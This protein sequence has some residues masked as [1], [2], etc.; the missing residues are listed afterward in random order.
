MLPGGLMPM[1]VTA[2]VPPIW[3]A[4]MNPRVEAW[5]REHWRAPA[6]AESEPPAR[7]E[8]TSTAARR[9]QLRAVLDQWG[10]WFIC[11]L[12]LILP[13]INDAFGYQGGIAFVI[14]FGAL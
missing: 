13:F 11:A 14:V 1:F 10:G 6:E 12:L 9:R 7:T 2:M 3:F 5:R 8:P 4:V